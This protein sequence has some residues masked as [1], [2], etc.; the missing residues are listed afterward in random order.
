MHFSSKKLEEIIWHIVFREYRKIESFQ[1]ILLQVWGQS[2][3]KSLSEEVSFK[4]CAHLLW[5]SLE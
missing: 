4:E 2:E 1:V 3:D 5:G